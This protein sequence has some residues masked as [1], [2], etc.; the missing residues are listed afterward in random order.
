MIPSDLLVYKSVVKVPL[1][2]EDWKKRTKLMAL[3]PKG[4]MKIRGFV[5]YVTLK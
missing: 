4:G 5:T 1:I 2:K 3:Y